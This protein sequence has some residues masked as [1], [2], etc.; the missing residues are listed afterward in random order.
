MKALRPAR[1]LAVVLL[2]LSVSLTGIYLPVS[3]EG[4]SPGLVYDYDLCWPEISLTSSERLYEIEGLD[5][6]GRSG[7]PSLPL[8]TLTLALP[9]GY[10]LD[11]ITVTHSRPVGLEIVARYPRNPLELTLSGGYATTQPYEPRS[12]ELSGTYQLEG[13]DVVCLNLCP[14]QWHED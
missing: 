13:V 7:S 11:D 2:A 5:L 9:P 10:L 1:A 4:A 14:I 8:R 12:W 6:D 3:G